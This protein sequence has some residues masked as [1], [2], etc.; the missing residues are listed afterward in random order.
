MAFFKSPI[1][2]D[3]LAFPSRFVDVANL[4]GRSRTART[5]FEAVAPTAD[6]DV[7]IM[8]PLES[9]VHIL[10]VKLASSAAA[11]GAI[12]IGLFRRPFDDGTLQIW[13]QDAFATGLTVSDTLVDLRFDNKGYATANQ[14]LWELA[15]LSERPNGK[16][17]FGLTT[18]TGTTATVDFFFEIGYVID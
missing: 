9:D 10:S 11:G 15:G 13:N 14:K 4:G 16:V 7:L 1:A 2:T 12:D 18:T 3:I 8:F 5:P 6:G 17:W